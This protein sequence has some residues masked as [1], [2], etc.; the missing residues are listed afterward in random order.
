MPSTRLVEAVQF[1]KT[2]LDAGRQF[3][4]HGRRKGGNLDEA[5]D[6]PVINGVIN[7]GGAIRWQ[8][9]RK[10]LPKLAK[11]HSYKSLRHFH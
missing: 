1:G 5:L 2:Q 3:G 11:F 6:L 8:V 4:A 10:H 9:R 7:L